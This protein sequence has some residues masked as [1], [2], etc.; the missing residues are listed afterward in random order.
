[1]SSTVSGLRRSNSAIIH[2]TTV[3]NSPPTPTTKASF[4]FPASTGGVYETTNY[5]HINPNT[6]VKS[7]STRRPLSYINNNTNNNTNNTENNNDN[8]HLHSSRRIT[9]GHSLSYSMSNSIAIGIPSFEFSN[10]SISRGNNE[11]T[12]ARTNNRNSSDVDAGWRW[13]YYIKPHNGS[14]LFMTTN[15]DFEYTERPIASSYFVS[16]S[17]TAAESGREF[18]LSF[19]DPVKRF[20]EVVVTRQF[21]GDNDFFE[22]LLYKKMENFDFGFGEINGAGTGSTTSLVGGGRGLLTGE[23]NVRLARQVA[24]LTDGAL[25]VSSERTELAWKGC[26]FLRDTGRQQ[27]KRSSSSAGISGIMREYVLQD[28]WRRTWVVGTK[29]PRQ[30]FDNDNEL[31]ESSNLSQFAN[32][33]LA[34][35]RSVPD[36]Y[37]VLQQNGLE[38]ED[39]LISV[40][41][42]SGDGGS[43]KKHGRSRSYDDR[44][45]DVSNNYKNNTP[46]FGTL[47][48]F[49]KVN[50]NIWPVSIALSVAVSY[51]LQLDIGNSSHRFSYSANTISSNGSSVSEGGYSVTETFK[52]LGRK[53]KEGRHHVFYGNAL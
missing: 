3:S 26:A 32:K 30:I 24:A 38:N 19:I 33:L 10:D 5:R 36:V 1:M 20:C 14:D 48:V 39:R 49:E 47:S 37:F 17:R 11:N 53:Y 31:D 8:N 42:R 21:R 50:H 52:R 44:F 45:R 13:K 27:Q 23:E 25:L 43:C 2:R 40:L 9:K 12:V 7:F 41:Q 34:P 29:K 18:S 46:D 51:A 16:V 6:S 22:V 4:R 15:P 28:D 35:R